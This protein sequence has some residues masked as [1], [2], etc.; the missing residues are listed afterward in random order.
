[1]LGQQRARRIH[2]VSQTPESANRFDFEWCVVDDIEAVET[3]RCDQ[4]IGLH[5]LVLSN[6]VV[7]ARLPLA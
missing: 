7:R 2:G 5:S 6:G 3:V 1:M 4:T